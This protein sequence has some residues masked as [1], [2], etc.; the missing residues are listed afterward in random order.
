MRTI[1]HPR[2]SAAITW[3][4]GAI[5]CIFLILAFA[6]RGSTPHNLGGIAIGLAF[7]LLIFLLRAATIPGALLGGLLTATLCMGTIAPTPGDWQHSALPPL[8]ALLILTLV[9]THF[10]RNVKEELGL[11]EARTGRR[12]AQV[13]ANLG[14][15]ALAASV[16]IFPIFLIP[17]TVILVAV[18]AAFVEAVADTVSSEMGQALRGKAVLITTGRSVPPGTDGG[19]SVSGTLAGCIA[20]ALVAKVAAASLSLSAS[21]ALAC[22]LAGIAGIFFDSW[23]GATLERRGSIGNDTV[24]FS[25]T[26]FSALLGAIFWFIF[27]R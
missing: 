6:L 11:A 20:G 19:M 17:R 2:Q 5:S 1:T 22:W 8:I 7:S 14:A 27:F 15:A 16:S 4:T 24:N 9:A 23:L 10:R 3:L 25:S 21:Q 13:C 12:A 18:A 26:A